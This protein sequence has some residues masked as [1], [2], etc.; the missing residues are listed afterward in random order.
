MA[1]LAGKRTN[2]K[3]NLCSV[4]LAYKSSDLAD[5]DAVETFCD[6]FFAVFNIS[7]ITWLPNTV[8]ILFPQMNSITFLEDAIRKLIDTLNI[9]SSQ[10]ADD[11]NGE[12]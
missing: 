7:V 10:G 3:C 2:L 1:G 11:I 9:S 12:Y 4:C 8:T 5:D 6:A